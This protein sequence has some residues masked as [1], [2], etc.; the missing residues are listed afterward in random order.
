MMSER[1]QAVSQLSAEAFTSDVSLCLFPVL[2]E[3]QGDRS[4]PGAVTLHCHCCFL[5]SSVLL[6]GGCL[7]T[8]V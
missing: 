2:G 4:S 6:G 8:H 3:E 5:G 1:V 7:E